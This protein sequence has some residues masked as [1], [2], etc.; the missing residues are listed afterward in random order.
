LI[1]THGRGT[2]SLITLNSQ[3]TAAGSHQMGRS[4]WRIDKVCEKSSV[5]RTHSI[6]TLHKHV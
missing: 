3:Y 1:R 6:Q 2:L 5:Y 4:W